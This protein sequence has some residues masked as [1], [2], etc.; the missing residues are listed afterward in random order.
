MILYRSDVT[1]HL[2]STTTDDDDDD[3]EDDDE[4][5]NQPKLFSAPV[6]NNAQQNEMF[7]VTIEN[8]PKSKAFQ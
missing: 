6:N 2:K 3:D 1:L 7:D 8:L 5:K 4:D